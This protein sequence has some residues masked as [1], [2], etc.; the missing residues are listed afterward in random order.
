MRLDPRTTWAPASAKLR[1]GVTRSRGTGVVSANGSRW[2][3]S[4]TTGFLGGHAGRA[5]P[6]DADERGAEDRTGEEGGG[7][8]R[9]PSAPW[10]SGPTDRGQHPGSH[11]GHLAERL[12]S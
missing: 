1:T 3:T 10:P 9:Q 6:T 12:E 8:G 4:R 7:H 2:V 5:A 11:V